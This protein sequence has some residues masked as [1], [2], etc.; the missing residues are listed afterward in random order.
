MKKHL[1]LI[2]TLI[3]VFLSINAVVPFLTQGHLDIGH[4]DDYE[5]PFVPDYIFA[6]KTHTDR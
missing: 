4:L 5:N 3:V 1:Y 2:S 6:E